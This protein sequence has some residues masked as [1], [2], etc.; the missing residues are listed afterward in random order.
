M[1]RRLNIGNVAWTTFIK[2]LINIQYS[3]LP[4]NDSK[5]QNTTFNIRLINVVTNNFE[6][7]FFNKGGV[8]LGIGLTYHKHLGVLSEGLH[9][10]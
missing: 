9:D 1:L 10:C 5:G 7:P 6:F 4:R 3:T 8:W 2:H